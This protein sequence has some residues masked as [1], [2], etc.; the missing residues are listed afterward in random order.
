MDVRNA[1][2]NQIVYESENQLLFFAETLKQIRAK[3]EIS[4]KIIAD[5]EANIERAGREVQ[6]GAGWRMQ[7][8]LA[9]GQKP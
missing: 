9:V 6:S 1:Q 4:K 7:C 2:T 3:G 8:V 5:A